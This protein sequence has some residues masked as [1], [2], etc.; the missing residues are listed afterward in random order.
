MSFLLMETT[1][2][3]T[4]TPVQLRQVSDHLMMIRP[5]SF[6]Y[7]EQTATT[8][9]FMVRDREHTGEEIRE[10]AKEEFD[11]MVDTLRSKGILVSVIDDPEG[12]RTPDSVFPNNWISTHEDGKIILYP[13]FAPNRRTERRNDVVDWVASLYP[14]VEVHDLSP[15]ELEGRFL[16]GTGSMILDRAHR[17]AYANLSPRT[18]E[19]LFRAF[20][21]KMNFEP[22]LFRAVD[23]RGQDIYHTNVM[24]ALAQTFAVICLEC[25]PAEE[26]RN[27]IASK[28]KE[29]GHEL[30]E[31]DYE[32][33]TSFAGNMLQVINQEGT[34][35]TILSGRAF[36]SLD[37]IQ[38][39]AIER[40]NEL[41]VVDLDLIETCGGGSVRCMMAEL[42]YPSPKP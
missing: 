40:H 8:N 16:E 13:M 42:F 14:V 23:A 21:Q 12:S 41:I 6:A 22:Q 11:A 32:Q 29:T 5:R 19:A 25:M 35:F 17:V 31:L 36:E 27:H 38:I 18:D 15:A 4:K 20:C 37:E 2:D 33:V 7:N 9:S 28:L 3:S 24:M 26:E 34:P 10:L 30:I 39:Q 1:S